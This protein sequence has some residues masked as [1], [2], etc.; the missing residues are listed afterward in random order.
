MK[1][2]LCTSLVFVLLSVVGCT[3]E[4]ELW[5][6]KAEECMESDPKRA[7]WCLQQID[8]PKDMTDNQQARYALLYTQAMHKN[9]MPLEDDSLVNVAVDYFR[10]HNDVRRLAKSLLYKGILYKQNDRVEKAV[11]AFSESERL[12]KSVDDDQYKAL[13]FDQYGMLLSNQAMYDE[14]LDYFKQTLH[15]ELRGDSAH[16]V[17]STYRRIAMLYGVLGMEDSA[18]NYYEKGL[19]YADEKE[20]RSRN[21]YLLLQNYA[22][23]LKEGGEY[24]E[25]ERLLYECATGMTDTTYVYTLYSS[26]A[27]LHY[28]KEE[29]DTALD[30]AKRIL[31]SRDSLTVCGGYLRLY[32]IYRKLGMLDTAVYYHDLYRQYDN[33]LAMRRQPSRVAVIPHKQENQLLKAE[34]RNWQI[35]L[36][37]WSSV[38][39]LFLFISVLSFRWLRKRYHKEQQNNLSQLADVKQILAETEQQLGETVV[40][41]GG[42][43]G[44]V[45]NQTNAINRLK[46]EYQQSKNEHKDEIKLLRESMNAQEEN[47]RKLKEDS[48]TSVQMANQYKKELKDLQKELKE[49]SDRLAAMEHQRQIDQLIEHFVMNGQDAVAIDLL[50]QLKFGEK[51]QSRYDIRSSEYIPLLRVLLESESPGMSAILDGSGLERNKLTMCYLIALGLDDIDMMSRAACLAP[52]SVKAYRKECREVVNS[53]CQ[54]LL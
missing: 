46:E 21:Y 40:S 36:W 5:I 54:P 19:S 6:E 37:M 48:R 7:Y 44:V 27:S 9:R 45:T 26:L 29:Y 38:G 4:Q 34:N 28:E 41:L 2:I 3:D 42:L 49:K 22:T 30:Y 51:Y 53:Y 18:R 10:R 47:Y 33:D 12:F 50:Q 20:V 43:K 39:V 1:I 32:Q 35:K 8:S 24:A 25:A 16:Y 31:G 15:Y 11:E 17:V 23:F 14:A 13:L 52:N